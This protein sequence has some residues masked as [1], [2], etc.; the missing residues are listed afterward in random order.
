MNAKDFLSQIK[1]FDKMIH[2]K[3]V[4][5]ERLKAIAN[6]TT[7]NMSG[8][9]V[10]STSNPQKMA[11]AVDSYL[12]IEREVERDKMMLEEKRREIIAVI[13]QLD[14]SL[15][16]TVLYNHYVEKK[17]LKKIAIEEHYSYAYIIEIHQDAKKKVEKILNNSIKPYIIL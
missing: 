13:E 14:N 10:Q 2:N 11:D 3:Q 1:K 12:D 8:E 5:I 9:R 16:Y 7:P 4:E 17:K 6:S 15:H